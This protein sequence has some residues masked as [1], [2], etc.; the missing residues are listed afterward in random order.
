VLW[1]HR[2]PNDGRFPVLVLGCNVGI[3]VDVMHFT[4]TVHLRGQDG[5]EAMVTAT[6]WRDAVVGFVDAVQAFYDASPPRQ[7]L[8]DDFED[9]GWRTFWN[10]WRERRAAT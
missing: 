10:E 2:Y 9:E 3:D 4:G 6:E 5:T 1:A 8:G 7:P